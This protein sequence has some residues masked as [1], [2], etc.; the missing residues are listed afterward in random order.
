[1]AACALAYGLGRMYDEPSP[2]WEL[3]ESAALRESIA[4]LDQFV[5]SIKAWSTNLSP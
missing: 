2:S 1:M 4:I 5:A 3:N